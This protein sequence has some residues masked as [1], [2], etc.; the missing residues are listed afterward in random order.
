MNLED[1]MMKA[2][3]MQSNMQK[4]QE[5]LALAEV[6]G[7]A[8]SGLVRVVMTG[9]HT[10]KSLQLDDS[11]LSEDKDML[12]DLIVAAVNDAARN[13]ENYSAHEMAKVTSGMGLPA[14]FKMPF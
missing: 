14:G 1:L 2:Q 13:L 3:S 4:A 12:E 6:T 8:G 7:E 11:L 5:D 9:R 10:L